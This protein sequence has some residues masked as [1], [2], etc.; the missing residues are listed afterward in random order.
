MII[1]GGLLANA[2]RGEFFGHDDVI[3]FASGVSNSK[4]TDE[5]EFSRERRLLEQYLS[6]NIPLVYF[7]TC[8]VIDEDL[9]HTAYV[10]HKLEMESLV[11]NVDSYGIFRLPQVVGTTKNP[12][13]LIN[14]LYD[15]ISRKKRFQVWTHAER[16]LIDVEDVAK[17]VSEILRR[18][19]LT[20]ISIN[21][22]S[23]M[24]TPI[25]R[26]VEI[27]EKIIGENAVFDELPIGSYYSIDVNYSMEFSKKIGIKFDANYNENLLKKYYGNK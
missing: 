16:N 21:I 26:I 14:Y 2:F 4:E 1:G 8:S 25:V 27:L 19:Q 9:K 24:S 13:T 22:A 6:L 5:V 17:I 7:S 10:Q 3:I 15:Q 20:K 23:P 18:G 11:K 12:N